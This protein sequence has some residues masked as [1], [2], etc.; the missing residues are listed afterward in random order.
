[1]AAL[2]I[3]VAVWLLPH[4]DGWSL[5]AFTV[6]LAAFVTWAHRANLGLLLRGEEHRF[7]KGPGRHI[8]PPVEAGDQ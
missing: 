3:P 4:E 6:A 7:G 1:L 5:L 8:V 2:T